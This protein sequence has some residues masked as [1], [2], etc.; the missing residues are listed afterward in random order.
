MSILRPDVPLQVLLTTRGHPFDRG[1][2]HAMLDA[3]PGMAFTSVEQ[4]A[5]QV[6]FDPGLAR[7]YSAFLLYDMAGVVFEAP[8]RVR[9]EEPP[10]ALKRG[11]EALCNEG[12]GFVVLH[13]AIA[14]WPTWE[15]WAEFCGARFHYA[16]AQL[17]G[18]DWP[19]SGYRFDITHRCTPVDRGH[20]VVAGLE[21]GFELRDELYCCPVFEDRVTPLLRSDADF[22]DQQFFSAAAAV[23]GRRNHREGWQHPPGSD[24]VAWTHRVGRS[25]VVTILCGDG[26]SAYASPGLQR[27]LANAVRYVAKAPTSPSGPTRYEG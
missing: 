7:P 19:D 9:F 27:L 18:R 21:A 5:A 13:H 3:L 11:L 8:G 15:G 25:R 26:P 22:S 4:P 12:H 10:E 14:A 20:P 2:F 1:A 23:A 17:R 16:P 6:F 24:L